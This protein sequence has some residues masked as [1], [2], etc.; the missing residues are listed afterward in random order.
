M[1]T[2]IKMDILRYLVRLIAI[3]G[4][5]FGLEAHAQQDAMNAQYMINKIM[6]NPGYAG[7]KEQPNFA[8]MHRSQWIGFKGAP[9]TSVLAFDSPMKKDEFAV[10]GTLLFDKVGPQTRFA[11]SADF[12]YRLRLNNKATIS[13]GA[14]ATA[15]L[16][17]ANLTDLYLISDYYGGVDDAFIYNTRGVFLPNVGFGAFYYK[18][19]HYIG[20]SVPKMI[21]NKLEKRGTAEFELLNGRQ[22]STYYLTAGKIWKLNKQVKLQ[23]NIVIRGV[24]GAPVSTGVFA[25]AIL[26]D[27]FTAGLYSHIGENAGLLFQW[28]INKQFRVGYSFDVATSRLISTNFGSHELSG[29]YVM[30]TRKKRIIYPR[31]F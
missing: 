5:L 1:E 20:F 6:L 10:G 29:V 18:K 8:A 24:W 13:F 23:P 9:T 17:Q 31:Y 19:D 4:L 21:R 15:E 11:M 14:K 12:A 3:S 30:P 2:H 27:Q 28:Q 7:Y 26:M 22:E 16:Y 25:N